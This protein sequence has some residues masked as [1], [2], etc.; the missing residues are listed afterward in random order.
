[1]SIKLRPVVQFV[2]SFTV[3]HDLNSRA[4]NAAFLQVRP[5]DLDALQGKLTK[6]RPSLWTCRASQGGKI[7]GNLPEFY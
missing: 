2:L 4:S 6:S 7:E 5:V 1:M 3:Y